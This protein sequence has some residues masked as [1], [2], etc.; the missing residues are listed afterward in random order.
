EEAAGQAR[1][2]TV[3]RRR[4]RDR[5]HRARP[6]IGALVVALQLGAA[7]PRSLVIRDSHQRV[8]V[9]IVAT[10]DGPMLRPESLADFMEMEL[11]REPGGGAKYRLTVWGAE[12]ELEAGVRVV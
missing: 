4:S 7:V 6:M 12:M 10:S 8:R 2:R 5:A 11:R 3:A 9:P 1:S